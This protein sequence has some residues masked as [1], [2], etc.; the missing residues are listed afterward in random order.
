MN[1]KTTQFPL[2][3]LQ[4]CRFLVGPTAVGKTDVALAMSEILPIEVIA[5]DSMTLYRGMDIGTAK[6]S[7]EEQKQL[8]HRLIDIIEPHE[9]YSISE[10]IVAA[11]SN[12]KEILSQE[13]IPMFVGGTG[14]Y[15]R[16]ILRGVFEGPDADWDFRNEMEAKAKAN[17]NQWLQDELR[18]VD[19][20]SADRLHPNDQR[21][22]IRAMEVHKLTGKSLTDWHQEKPLPVENRPSYIHWLEPP[23]EWVYNRIDLRVHKMME[24]GLKQEVENL[25][26]ESEGMGRTARQGL[27]YKEMIAHL[28]GKFTL[29]EVIEEIQLRSR[30]FA[31]RQH[32]WFRN[33]EEC[34]S[35]EITGEESPAEIAKRL[36]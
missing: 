25:L 19:P 9:E 21:R 24:L 16:G 8:P 14:L 22:I 26:A 15:L 18:K 10:Y 33:L 32:T 12:V 4:Q 20:Q 3:L 30:Q 23:R 34:E 1:A 17:G 11:I 5:L 6:P 28:E 29:E 2:E 36:V 7:P 31:K 27:G 13:K 35:L